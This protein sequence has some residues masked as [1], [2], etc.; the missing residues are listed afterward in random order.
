MHGSAN[1][2]MDGS[3]TRKR[4]DGMVLA[5]GQRHQGLSARNVSGI[6]K[7]DMDSLPDKTLSSHS[8]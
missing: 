1:G 2:V 8:H 5:E 4:M 7:R 3:I 6:T